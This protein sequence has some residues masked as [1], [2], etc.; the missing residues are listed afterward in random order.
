MHRI[1]EIFQEWQCR[2]S[3][4]PRGALKTVTLEQKRWPD[5]NF[6]RKIVHLT[7]CNHGTR[8][9]KQFQHTSTSQSCQPSSTPLNTTLPMTASVNCKLAD[10]CSFSRIKKTT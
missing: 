6:N 3:Q 5:S 10:S 9:V 8:D 4:Y 7:S 2:D 1:S